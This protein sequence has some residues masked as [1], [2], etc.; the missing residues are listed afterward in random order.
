MQE[1]PISLAKAVATSWLPF[2]RRGREAA[3]L[4][5]L[6]C[7][8]VT[9]S[10]IRTLE[11][12][13]A[14]REELLTAIAQAQERILIAALYLQDD[15]AGR[16]VLAAIYAAK[17]R[18]PSLRIAVFVDWHRAQ[19]G[20]VGKVKSEGNVTLYREMATRLGPGVNIHGVPIQTREL[21]GVLHLKG[22]VIDD[23]VLY[24]GAS[25]NDVYLQQKDR[26]RLDRYHKIQD[27]RLADCL[28]NFLD[29]TLIVSPA[30]QE[31]SQASL[32]R[33]AA[34]RPAI[35]T[36][37]KDLKRAAYAFSGGSIRTG[38]VGITPLLGLGARKNVLNETILAL[39]GQARER[40]VLLTPYFN[41][42]HGLRAAIARQLKQG[43][44]VVIVVGD[45]T[46]ND[47]YIPPTEPFKPIG[48]LPY[49]Y[50]TNLRRFC[51]SH[52]RAIDEGLLDIFLWK[53]GENSYHLKGLWIDDQY[54]LLTGNN[55]NPRAWRLDLENGLLLKD[56]QGLL[57]D[58]NRAELQRILSQARR[59]SAYKDLQAMADY[60]APVA[61]ILKHLTRVR[62]DRLF[63][64]VL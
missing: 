20:L 1:S 62:V 21:M 45:K 27:R 24:S 11:G 33:T 64:Q 59:I 41:L 40:L 29:H 61:R 6:P 46:A 34:L 15:E 37:R 57:K 53:D 42:P 10:R 5:Q 25:L 7:I 18:C 23:T 13:R 60:P 48:V 35:A 54:S 39:I 56:P 4:S 17:G 50:E 8:P 22:F 43:H 26:Y 14:F 44:K 30:V 32:P 52:Q 49:L 19:R 12:P 36:F 63:N 2:R 16:E 28:A 55:L 3:G 38:E 9:A 31:L 58:Q 47:F 51:R